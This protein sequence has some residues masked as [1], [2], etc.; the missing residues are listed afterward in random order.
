MTD[1]STTVLLKVRMSCEGCAGAVR[2]VL[3]AMEG[4]ESYDIDLKEQKVTVKGNLKPEAVLESVSKARKNT[5]F[6]EAE[7]PKEEAA[8]EAKAQAPAE[9]KAEVAAESKEEAP[10]ESKAE[11]DAE[12][13]EQ[14][15]AEPEAKSAETVAVA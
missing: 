11:A 2:R 4:V 12:A 3:D 6:W 7:A 5:S 9:N 15:A 10:A 14:V 13:K 8:A 1:Q